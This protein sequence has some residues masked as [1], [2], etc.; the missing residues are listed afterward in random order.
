MRAAVHVFQIYRVAGDDL[1][2]W[3]MVSANGRAVARAA[4]PA[5]SA[6][7]THA[8]IA[9]LSRS[10]DDV[11]ARLRPTDD[12]R[13]RWSLDHAGTTVVVGVG[14]HD[15]RVR[16][17][18]A[19]RRFV[20]AAPLAIIST[21]T[22]SF[23][24]GRSPSTNTWVATPRTR[25]LPTSAAPFSAVALHPLRGAGPNPPEP[26]AWPTAGPAA[27]RRLSTQDAG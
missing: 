7:N 26:S 15:R 3:R 8:A 13:W 12:G 22:H 9:E 16:C 2:W 6:A 4:V 1:Y 23:Q 24:Q 11:T 14:D 10:L 25:A 17:E 19:W 21:S 5:V 20:L 27:T 18:H